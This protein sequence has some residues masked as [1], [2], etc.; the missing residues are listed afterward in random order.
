MKIVELTPQHLKALT[1]FF[2]G[3]PERDRTF[4]DEDLSDP[5]IIAALPTRPGKRWV[6][7]E[8]TQGAD[9]AG[10]ASMRTHS[11]WSDHVATLHLVIHPEHR[12]SGVGT[13]LAVGGL[14]VGDAGGQ[15]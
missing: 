1:L 2:A 14:D 10:F 15:S 11:G 8:Q 13:E 9:I 6:V 12:H 7:I 4:L 3:L 5:Q